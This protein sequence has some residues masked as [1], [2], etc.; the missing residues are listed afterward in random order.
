MAEQILAEPQ[1]HPASRVTAAY[2]QAL[3]RD[4]SEKETTRALSHIDE[5][6]T[7]LSGADSTIRAWA[8][9]CQ[10]LLAS[11]EFRYID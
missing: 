8:S 11:N 10:A 2:R 9:F 5:Q 3:Q 7:D 1:A 6:E 4:P